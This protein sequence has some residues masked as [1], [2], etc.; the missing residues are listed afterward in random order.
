MVYKSIIVEIESTICTI[1][2]NRPEVLN[3]INQDMFMEIYDALE[4]IEHDSKINAVIITGFGDRSFSAGADIKEMLVKADANSGL[5]KKTTEQIYLPWKIA[6]FPKP[7]IGA[8]NGLAYG[9]GAVLAS[10]MD[11]RVGC[12]LSKFRF[13]AASYGRLNATWS[14]PMQVGWPIAKEL[15]FTARV[16]SADEA[17]KIGLLNYLVDCDQVLSKAK[18]VAIQIADNDPNMVAGIKELLIQDIGASWREQFEME[19][20]LVSGKLKPTPI[21]EGFKDFL[22]RKREK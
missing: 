8:I 20:D 4:K 21:L 7:V 11:I 19:L 13:L 15:L 2:L 5:P 9:G 3:A 14:L 16:L 10:C 17:L 18:E 1:I 22:E 12:D 6:S